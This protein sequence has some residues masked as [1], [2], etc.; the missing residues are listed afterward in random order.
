MLFLEN[1]HNDN[2]REDDHSS[3]EGDRSFERERSFE[4]E[5]SSEWSETLNGRRQWTEGE[6]IISS[7]PMFRQLLP[8]PLRQLEC[9]F[10]SQSQYFVSLTINFQEN[11]EHS[12]LGL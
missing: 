2:G 5:Q 10:S 6:P 4:H 7:P 9:R 3:L 1:E 8:P 11:H 12:T